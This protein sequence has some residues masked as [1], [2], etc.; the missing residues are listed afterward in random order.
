MKEG[1]CETNELF[2]CDFEK[3]LCGFSYDANAIFNWTRRAGKKSNLYNTGPSID[4]TVIEF[5]QVY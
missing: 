1:Y 3:D 2:I 5:I 4:H